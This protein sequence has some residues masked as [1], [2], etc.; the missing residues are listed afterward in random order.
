[1][2]T[3]FRI[4]DD[5]VVIY[6]PTKLAEGLKFAKKRDIRNI[7]VQ[8]SLLEGNPNNVFDLDLSAFALFPEIEIVNICDYFKISSVGQADSFYD[9]QIR[10]LTLHENFKFPLELHRFAHLTDLYVTETAKLK[11]HK[12]PETLLRAQ[13]HKLSHDDLS[14][15]RNTPKLK[16][17]FLVSPKISNL[18]GLENCADLEEVILL[19]A[20]QLTDIRTINQLAS[21]KELHFERCKNMTQSVLEQITSSSLKILH[22]RFPVEDLSFLKNFPNL[23]EFYFTD[24]KDGNLY[25]LLDSKIR[26]AGFSKKKHYTHRYDEMSKL[27][28]EKQA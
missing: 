24:I 12:L 7:R 27:L 8:E 21:L 17:L 25:P 2:G 5:C 28:K 15:F 22:V 10:S 20:S 1:M 4:E 16:T 18:S 13:I 9:T 23:E 26:S 3:K 11:I 6:P 19:L 14:I